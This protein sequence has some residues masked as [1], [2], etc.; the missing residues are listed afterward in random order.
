MNPL[1]NL[2]RSIGLGFWR[3][4][5]STA[6][7]VHPGAAREDFKNGVHA[8]LNVG[9]R[10]LDT[11]D[12]YCPDGDNFGHN[13]I[14]VRETMSEWDASPE[15]KAEVI[16]ATKGGIF[17]DPEH[18]A[19]YS[20]YDYLMGAVE[21]SCK[22]LGIDEIPL[23]QHHRLDPKLTFSEQ[24]KNIRKLNENAPIKLLGVSNYNAKQLLQALDVIGGPSEGGIVSVQNQLN[25]VYRQDYDVLA[26]CEDHGLAYLPWSPSKGVMPKDEGTKVYEM[27]NDIAR[28]RGVTPF[29]ISQA[30]SRTLSP[31]IVPLPGVTRMASILDAVSA[32]DLRLTAAE[33]AALKDLPESEPLD[34]EL[35]TGQP[36]AE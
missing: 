2:K 33:I 20:G 12:I 22:R 24:V 19:K 21:A 32:I 23:W 1:L 26:I 8:A 10:L 35:V 13:E 9:V 3:A 16:I 34:N 7:T 27:F 25:P 17:R 28:S 30:W 4:S 11:A 36:L 18:V 14:L 31:N 6:A 29:A 15:Q 5:Y